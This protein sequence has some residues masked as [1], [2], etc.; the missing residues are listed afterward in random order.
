MST[1]A[2]LIVSLELLV[3]QK[4]LRRIALA[5]ARFLMDLGMSNVH[6]VF[7]AAV[8]TEL[9]ARGH[10]CLDL[11]LFAQEPC[12]LLEWE[13]SVW[14]QLSADFSFPKTKDGWLAALSV[15]EHIYVATNRVGEMRVDLFAPVVNEDQRQ[16]LVLQD[17]RLYLRRYWKDE[18]LIADAVRGRA[19][20]H[21]NVIAGDVRRWV[22]VLFDLSGDFLSNS[23]QRSTADIDAE[24]DWQKV[25]C[26]IAVRSHFSIITGGPGTGKTYTVARLIAL[27]LALSAHPDRLRIA[28]AA[29]TGKAA[30]RLKQS[31][32][33]ALNELAQKLG[34][35][36]PM[37]EMSSRIGAARTL[38]SLLGARPDTRSFRH[39][40]GNQLDID[41]LIVDEAS[42]IHLEMM[43][44]LLDAL[45]QTT[46]LV[47]LGDKD[48]LASVEAG[49]V[50][51][52]LCGN[53]ET[54]GYTS[55]TTAYIQQAT[56][57]AIASHFSGDRGTIA[58]Q[59][60]MLR[61][62]R[63]FSGAIGAL[64]AAVNN[65][66]V[67]EANAC[68]EFDKEVL[69]WIGHAK[70][71][72]LLALAYEGRVGAK[73]GYR[74]YLELIQQIPEQIREQ[75]S[76]LH[77]ERSVELEETFNQWVMSVL[78]AFDQFRL[79]CA[80]KE[81]EWGVHSLNA[82]IEHGLQ[83]RGL[84]KRDSDWYIGRPVMVTRNDYNNNV[85][86][87]DIGLALPDV[88]RNKPT[89]VYFLDGNKLRSML[90]SRLRYVETAYA[91]TVHKSQGS[92]F[93]HTALV[94][95]QEMSPVL[96]RELIY[97]GITRARNQF[98][99]ISPVN[100]IWHK[101]L[102]VRTRRDSG[103]MSVLH[104]SDDAH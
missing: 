33:N 77:T 80:V 34:S 74:A 71:S 5:F 94:L 30:A 60:V 59:T 96:T 81:G 48:Q 58:Q 16:L 9:E 46:V 43:A 104:L 92:E 85:F 44:S 88:H 56:G 4:K 38:H 29:P 66:N 21:I 15:S 86:N 53:A 76:E 36:L 37:K 68:F 32:D 65:G 28:L 35:S 20:Q 72:Q 24:T 18:V 31:L 27:I 52:D 97:T 70:Q 22:D 47:L 51:G 10:I 69:N 13:V 89:R 63:R 61:K 19:A 78:L 64:A 103:L 39:H 62:S 87:G 102:S 2:E 49:S 7:C 57:Q 84:I 99:L 73:G 23:N 90:A 79:L 54:G 83:A 1:C 100:Q 8:L 40:A 42:M 95:P 75:A 101:A 12:A 93:S 17:S 25:A 45:P 41:V 14:Q 50:L 55:E 91:M 98:S 67:E 26:A 11:N 6:Q 3:E 82:A